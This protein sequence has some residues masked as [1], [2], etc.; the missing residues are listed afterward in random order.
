MR[1]RSGN[2]FFVVVVVVAIAVAE[3]VVM[4]PFIRQRYYDYGRLQRGE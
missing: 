4:F 3:A 2:D 1:E